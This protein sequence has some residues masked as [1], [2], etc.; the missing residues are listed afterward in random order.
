MADPEV[1]SRFYREMRL[2]SQLSSPHI[3]HAF[4]AGPIG[5]MHCLVMEYVEG[6][7]LGRLVK[8][9]GPLPV[10]QAAEYIRQAAV[11]L[12]H[13]SERGLVHRDIKPSNILVS[14]GV[15]SGESSATHRSPLTTH[16]AKISD[17]G[18]ARWRP[19]AAEQAATLPDGET[20]SS[21]L[22]PA[23]SVMMGTPD[24][25]APEQALDFH[26]ADVRA[27]LYSLGCTLYYLLTGQPPFPGGTLAQKLLNHQQTPVP[28]VKQ[29]RSDVPAELVKILDRLLAKRPTDR[30]Q[31]PAELI[32][33][34]DLYTGANTT[35]V[36][37]KRPTRRLLLALAAS[38]ASALLLVGV[39]A[40]ALS[41]PGTPTTPGSAKASA[42]L[43]VKPPTF[44]LWND[45]V[46]PG[47]PA[48]PDNTAVELGVKFRCDVP[49]AVTAIRF[50]K[51]PAN[52]GPHVGQLW[53]GTGELL[54]TAN[55]TNETESGWQRALFPA[56][57]PI[58]A[59]VVYVAS[60]HTT[61]GNYAADHHY[62]AAKGVDR[63]PLHALAD[64]VAG[65]NGVF[66]QGPGGTFPNETFQSLNYWVDV[67]FEPASEA[68][69]HPSS[70]TQRP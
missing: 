17:L 5:P 49:G 55:F 26:A 4:D 1:V 56:P 54:A 61:T 39:L 44:S 58:K 21:S 11:G 13:L 15:V 37:S 68:P 10:R 66:R 57:V 59:N 70:I 43:P 24:Y 2:V 34:L 63:G 47:R 46:V 51:S 53:Q 18:L 16:Q 50:Y 65:G 9:S 67:I 42:P 20:S 48:A 25:L 28:P 35:T 6:T 27:D 19:G 40:F 29:F 23:G 38:V 12:Q 45:K 32:A 3:V 31:T 14:G 36:A 7:D 60:Y 22:T 33:A 8:K 64:G 69:V 52:T 62:F 30:Y 41:R